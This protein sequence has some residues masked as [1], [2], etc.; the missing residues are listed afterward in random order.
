L[1]G[2]D[3]CE[4]GSARISPLDLATIPVLLIIFGNKLVEGGLLKFI[5]IRFD[6]IQANDERIG[7]LKELLQMTLLCDRIEAIDVPVPD[8]NISLG[9]LGVLSRAIDLGGMRSLKAKKARKIGLLDN[10]FLVLRDSLALLDSD[11]LFLC[12]SLLGSY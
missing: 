12:D 6:F 9:K 3:F 4:D 11:F 10:L 1:Q 8:L 5:I 7:L 2:L